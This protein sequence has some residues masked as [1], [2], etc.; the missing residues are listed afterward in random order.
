VRSK[1]TWAV[2]IVAVRAAVCGSAALV[3]PGKSHN[4]AAHDEVA[5]GDIDVNAHTRPRRYLA[6]RARAEH[7]AR[8]RVKGGDLE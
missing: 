6:Q 1:Q 5:F 7:P 4:D 3:T 8:D 2:P